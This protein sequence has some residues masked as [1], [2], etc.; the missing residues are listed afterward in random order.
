ME[1]ANVNDLYYMAT[2][3]GSDVL[4]ALNAVFDLKLDRKNYAPKELNR[5]IKKLQ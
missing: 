1:V 5:K 2:Y 3:K 4:D